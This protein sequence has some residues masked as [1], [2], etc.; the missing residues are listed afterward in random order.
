MR[1]DAR[2]VLIMLLSVVCVSFLWRDV[3]RQLVSPDAAVVGALLLAA[4]LGWTGG[5]FTE[6][7]RPW[8]TKP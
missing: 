8:M 6:R 5:V 7:S 3:A 1:P 4:A 2:D